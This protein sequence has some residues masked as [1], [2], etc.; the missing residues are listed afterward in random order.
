MAY[1]E[2]KDLFLDFLL[3]IVPFEF[4]ILWTY[5]SLVSTFAMASL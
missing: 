2:G 1:N 5:P 3:E 4:A